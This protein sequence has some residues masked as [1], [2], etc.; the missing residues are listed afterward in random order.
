ML[1]VTSS[2][3][4]ESHSIGEWVQKQR[5][6]VELNLDLVK[7]TSEENDITILLTILQNLLVRAMK[8]EAGLRTHQS[9][10]GAIKRK[11]DLNSKV[12]DAALKDA[13]YRWG[14]KTGNQ[15]ISDVVEY[16]GGKLNWNWDIYF[17]EAKT[18]RHI[19]F[20]SD[21]LLTIKNIGF[22]VRDLA[23]SNF[24]PYYAAFDLHVARV[25][26]RIGLLNYGFELLGDPKIEMGNNPGDT[27]NY[28]FLHKLFI[29]LAELTKN[30]FLPA[31]LD[32]IFWNFGRTY[33][34]SEPLCPSCPIKEH[35]LTGRS[36]KA[37]PRGKRNVPQV[38]KTRHSMVKDLCFISLPFGSA[39]DSF[40]VEELIRFLENSGRNYIIVGGANV[41]FSKHSKPNSLDYWI[42]KNHT[43]RSDTRQ[44][45]A[46][47]VNALVASGRFEQ[48]DD[49]VCPDSGR[50]CHGIILRSQER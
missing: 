37:L 34:K 25:P 19:N 40:D 17:N 24:D 44:A 16:F 50:R 31:D 10:Q 14:I 4:H 12:Y 43:Q 46:E 9:L 7:N 2:F 42:R 6:D 39:G 33:C 48:R 21:K 29:R 1:G 45:V 13:N 15:V 41:P 8:G 30:E 36:R 49:L 47:V 22:K 28:L 26:T 18:Q 11:S 3:E 20:T 5:E 35:C 32:R 27:K 38:L 23:L